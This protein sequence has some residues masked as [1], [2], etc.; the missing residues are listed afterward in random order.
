[1]CPLVGKNIEKYYHSFKQMRVSTNEWIVLA[2]IIGY[3]AF[4]THPP[5]SHIQDFLN[6]PI[7]HVIALLSIAYVLIYQSFISGLFLTVAY[8]MTVNSVTEYMDEKQQKPEGPE[9]PAQPKS[10]GVPPPAITGM[11]QSKLSS[12]PSPTGPK[13][14]VAPQGEKAKPTVKAPAPAPPKTD[15]TMKSKKNAVENFAS[16]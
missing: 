4:F 11:L 9:T 5:P 1:M 7:G 3:I 6:T 2:A 10:S 16:F 8:V 14:G 12:R 15:T 13:S